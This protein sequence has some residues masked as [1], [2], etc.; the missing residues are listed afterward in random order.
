V[1]QYLLLIIGWALF[2]KLKGPPMEQEFSIANSRRGF[3][4]IVD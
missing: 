4:D 3:H 2:R 1:D